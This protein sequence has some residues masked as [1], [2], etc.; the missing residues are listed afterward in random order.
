MAWIRARNLGA[1]CDGVSYLFGTALTDREREDIR[2]SVSMA[3]GAKPFRFRLGGRDGVEVAACLDDPA[4]IAYVWPDPS[5]LDSKI[6]VVTMM[7]SCFF[8]IQGAIS[9]FEEGVPATAS[10][11]VVGRTPD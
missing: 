7:C 8:K 4:D 9:R 2:R 10:I 5:P 3:T 1:W 11:V 6:E